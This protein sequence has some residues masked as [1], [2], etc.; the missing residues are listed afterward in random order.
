MGGVIFGWSRTSGRRTSGTSRPSPGA[1]VLAVFA[2]ISWGKSHFKKCLGKRLEVPDIRG[3]L[4][5]GMFSPPPKFFPHPL[6]RSLTRGM[7]VEQGQGS[8]SFR[9]K[10]QRFKHDNQRLK[11][12]V[13]LEICGSG[14][15]ALR[16]P[17]GEIAQSQ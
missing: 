11:H 17:N 14:I 4:I 13:V 1:Q 16:C 5:Y 3:L 6:Y 10:V 15:L 8:R 9:S 7:E 2:F 12:C